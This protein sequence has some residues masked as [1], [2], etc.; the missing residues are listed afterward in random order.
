MGCPEKRLTGSL[1]VLVV[2]CAAGGTDEGWDGSVRSALVG[3]PCSSHSEC[4]AEDPCTVAMCLAGTCRGHRVPGCCWA[5]ENDPTTGLSWDAPDLAQDYADAQCDRNDACAFPASCDLAT[6]TCRILA[7]WGILCGG[8]EECDD[9]DPCTRDA[10][11]C[12]ACE[13]RSEPGCCSSDGDCDDGLSCTVDA[14]VLGECRWLALPG[15]DCCQK[16]TD[17]PDDGRPCT[18]EA[19]ILDPV[20]GIRVCRHPL[21]PPCVAPVPFVEEFHGAATF[22]GLGWEVLDDGQDASQNWSLPGSGALGLD[23][24]VLFTGDPATTPLKTVLASPVLEGLAPVM[25]LQWRMVYEHA[26]PGQPVTLRTVAAGDGDLGHGAVLWSRTLDRDLEYRLLSVPI[27]WPT[28]WSPTIRIGFMVWASSS[29]PVASWQIDRVVVAPGVPNELRKAQ[30]WRCLNPTCSNINVSPNTM[31]AEAFGAY[32][33]IVMTPDEHYRYQACYKDL[34]GGGYQYFGFPHVAVD[35]G[36]PLDQPAFVTPVAFNG[37]NSCS[38]NAASVVSV[39][40]SAEARF[41]CQVDINPKNDAKFVGAY[42]IGI[43]AFDHW[44]ANGLHQASLESL[45]EAVITVLPPPAR[46]VRRLP[47]T[48]RAFKG[49][50]SSRR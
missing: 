1:G 18:A 24:Q 28:G 13:H 49:N 6:N 14:C 48:N 41:L 21:Q 25:T 15:A 37:Q 44:D 27:W 5:P 30:L 42:R 16:D 8:D 2:A 40:G 32:P 43:R 45:N 7:P 19:C 47:P 9:G 46:P 26:S 10:C 34:D 11:V 3:I 36:G 4:R 38:A 17:C 50:T 22:E 12:G 23:P 20:L 31:V 29:Q 35:T 39:C 33:D